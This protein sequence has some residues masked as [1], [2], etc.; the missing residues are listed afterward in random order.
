MMLGLK[1]FHIFF[2]VASIVLCL[3]VGAWGAQQYLQAG[4]QGGLATAIVFFLAGLALLIYAIR[5][6]GKLRKLE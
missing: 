5:Y 6:F 3:A 2:I 1:G 4:S